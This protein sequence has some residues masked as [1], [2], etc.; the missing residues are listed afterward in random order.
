MVLRFWWFWNKFLV[1]P[2]PQQI[3]YHFQYNHIATII[4]LPSQSLFK[5]CPFHLFSE[6]GFWLVPSTPRVLV[7]RLLSNFCL[8][9]Q[10]PL[11]VP[12]YLALQGHTRK[13]DSSG[14]CNCS[15]RRSCCQPPE[16]QDPTILSILVTA[17]CAS[18][19]DENS[20]KIRST[21]RVLWYAVCEDNTRRKTSLFWEA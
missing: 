19:L 5:F 2:I 21:Y 4:Q 16:K 20:Q 1:S 13:P 8:I 11:V 17:L 9:I 18:S 7:W 15:F 14:C 3:S 12:L 6:A 10:L